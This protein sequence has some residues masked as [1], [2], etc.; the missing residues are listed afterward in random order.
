MED[1]T[2]DGL[3]AK[4]AC[5]LPDDPKI[6]RAGPMGELLYIR[7]VLW[8]RE[9]LTDGVIERPVVPRLT[10][11]FPHPSRAIS[12]LLAANLWT[13]HDLGFA[14]PRQI[15][16]K[17]NPTADQVKAKRDQETARKRAYRGS[18]SQRDTWD[19]RRQSETETEAEAETEIRATAAAASTRV[20]AS[21]SAAVAGLRLIDPIA[22]LS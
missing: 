22:A 4:I 21:R 20:P 16:T 13:T 15:W 5:S 3:Y 1:L 2:V 6:I 8:C 9:H 11:G 7:S 19:T 18:V 12:R 10:I 17:W 14:I